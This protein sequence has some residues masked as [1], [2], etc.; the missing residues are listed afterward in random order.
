MNPKRRQRKVTKELKKPTISTKAEEA[1]KTEVEHRKKEKSV[2]NKRLK[3]NVKS[4]LGISKFKS[5]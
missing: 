3:M 4:I 2:S 1:L 5:L